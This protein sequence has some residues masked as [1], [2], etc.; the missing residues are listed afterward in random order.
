MVWHI[1]QIHVPGD[2]PIVLPLFGRAAIGRRPTNT[3]IVNDLAVSGQHC[4]IHCSGAGSSDFPKVEDCS[5]NGTYVNEVK[6]GKD[7]CRQLARGDVISLTKESEENAPNAMPRVQFR[8]E[9]T[10]GVS[11]AEERL[12]SQVERHLERNPSQ[13]E[14]PPS[15][16]GGFLSDIPLTAP[17]KQCFDGAVTGRERNAEHCFAQ[18]LLVQ[19]QQTKS[20]I[21]SELLIAQ[22]KL[23]EERQSSEGTSRELRKVR[24][25]VDEERAR[26]HEAEEARDRLTAEADALR[27]EKRQ[28]HELRVAHD[29]LRR[30]HEAAQ[31]ELDTRKRVCGQLEASQEQQRHEVERAAELHS[32]AAQQHA[33]LQTRARQAQERAERLEQ[34][35][36]DARRE[37]D[38]ALEE[39]SRLQ[40]ELAAE[41]AQREALAERVAQAQDTVVKAEAG[42][43]GAREVLDAATSRRAEL[44]CRAAAAQTDAEGARSA[45]RQSQQR[46]ASGRKMMEQL[47]TGG[48]AL[49]AELRRR[50]DV[51]EKALAAD[52]FDD[53]EDALANCG[54]T[55][56]QVTCRT[57]DSTPT[58]PH[59]DG[60]QG[61]AG[62]AKA[63][64][65]VS[66]GLNDVLAHAPTA[67][68][69]AAFGAQALAHASSTMLCVAPQGGA[70][71][72]GALT[73]AKSAQD[74]AE[75]AIGIDCDS[76]GSAHLSGVLLAPDNLHDAAVPSPPALMRSGAGVAGD[77]DLLEAA[78]RDP[79]QNRGDAATSAGA[80]SGTG[81]GCSTAWSLEMLDAVDTGLVERAPKRPRYD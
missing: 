6:V 63:T 11:T 13:P 1:I 17:E 34:Q 46:L 26:R 64:P 65:A 55:F 48:K 62:I 80:I 41:R 15:Q 66:S 27:A 57:E 18:D 4:I 52:C 67:V 3:I 77:D 25:Q 53:L 45:A 5:T 68:A 29:E 61:V 24:Q 33:E 31:A 47:H 9:W 75:K 16:P 72:R 19:E 73:G 36:A 44:E 78:S 7:E 12:P 56:A 20:K 70:A 71:E 76:E 10:V 8:L 69:C 39:G 40:R 81:V 42:E 2:L 50:A 23:E 74:P 54:P 49:S 32:K 30:K 59:H 38:R 43:R 14:R 22:R 51:W 21:T 37:A 58:K 28:L 79:D 60:S 35:H